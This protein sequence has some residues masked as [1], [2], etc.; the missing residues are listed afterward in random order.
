[1]GE[2]YVNFLDGMANMF[3]YWHGSFK[4]HID[5]YATSLQDIRGAIM[6]TD[7]ADAQWE[8]AYNKVVT[9][10]GDTSIEFEV[11]YMEKNVCQTIN[12]AATFYLYWVPLSY[13]QPNPSANA[14]YYM[15]VYKAAG[16]DF[17]FGGP[18][19]K[20][21]QPTGTITGKRNDARFIPHNNPR[22]NFAKDFP[23]FHSSFGAYKTEG[24][25]WGEKI[26]TIRELVH[27]KYPLFSATSGFVVNCYDIAG[28]TTAGYYT[29]IELFGIWFNAWRGSIIVTSQSANVGSGYQQSILL[30][31]GGVAVPGMYTNSLTN[32]VVDVVVPYYYQDLYQY[33]STDS[34]FQLTT[35]GGGQRFLWKCAGDDFS[36]HFLRAQPP[37]LF[38]PSNSQIGLFGYY[39]W[40]NSLSPS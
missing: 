27:R 13:N 26:T 36:F 14:P 6:I 3:T 28:Y 20:M 40:L 35:A 24:Y 39:A 5:F 17:E 11:P 30:G 2:D 21:F 34:N 33:T 16:A 29:G 9:I 22:A 8:N 4:F 12:A 7:T 10:T 32:P 18:V 25:V 19:E 37:G 31:N 38:L 23:A 15:V 1:L